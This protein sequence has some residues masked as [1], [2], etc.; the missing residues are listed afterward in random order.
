[1]TTGIRG[2]DNQSNAHV[3]FV[4]AEN[5]GDSKVVPPRTYQESAYAWVSQHR[6]KPLNVQTGRGKCSLWDD[7]WKIKAEWDDGQGEM[8]L[9]KVKRS[10]QDYK[11]TINEIGD[12]VLSER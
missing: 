8:V 11:M 4:N 3:S 9:A 12:I 10:P 2:C 1:M 6:D 5:P 7:D